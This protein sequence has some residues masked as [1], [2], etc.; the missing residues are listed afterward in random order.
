MKIC[1][2]CNSKQTQKI[3]TYTKEG[4]VFFK[5]LNCKV[6]FAS[7]MK[8]AGKSW[9]EDSQWY[10]LPSGKIPGLRWYEQILLDKENDWTGKKVLNIGCG[11]NIFLE[12]LKLKGALITAI[13]IN[14]KIIEF[15]ANI[16]K[17]EDC[18][19]SEAMAFV[20][21]YNGEKFNAIIFFE[22]L[23][24]LENPGEFVLALKNIMQNDGKIFF[25]VPNKER[26]SP[27]LS[28]WDNPPHHLTRWNK[29]SLS[30]FLRYNGFS[31]LK[32]K[33][34]PLIADD[35][36]R[37]LGIHF[38]VLYF[39]N[40]I[41]KGPPGKFN[42]LIYKMLYFV[43]LGFYKIIALF[44]RMWKKDGHNVYIVAVRKT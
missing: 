24:H 6:E 15:T 9:Y 30:L 32:L 4:Y 33:V 43:R 31:V 28:E 8:A 27:Q 14:N 2:A 22:V 25:S 37:L 36:L 26:L 18:F 1:P 23:E 17:I 41:K 11:R 13:D 10:E 38:G 39:E 42:L 7:P 40:K 44:C 29:E 34:A 12:Q 21:S 5:C 3:D 35:I 20:C 16:L 19:V